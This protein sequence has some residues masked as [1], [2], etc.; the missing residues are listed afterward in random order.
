[1]AK[2]DDQHF[3]NDHALSKGSATHLFRM[4][5]IDEE[6]H[7]SIVKDAEKRMKTAPRRERGRD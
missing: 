3:H 7:R 4:K 5:Y 6:K 2:R 1:M